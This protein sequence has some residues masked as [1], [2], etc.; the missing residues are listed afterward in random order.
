MAKRKPR[1]KTRVTL[2]LDITA[3]MIRKAFKLPAHASIDISITRVDHAEI[4][5]ITEDQ[6]LTATWEEI[7]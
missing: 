2:T 7:R 6:H 5:T 1:K 4:C 3:E